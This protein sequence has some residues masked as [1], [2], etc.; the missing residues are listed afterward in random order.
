MG[1]ITKSFLANWAF[2]HLESLYSVP[3]ME[4]ETPLHL[5]FEFSQH[6]KVIRKLSGQTLT[7]KLLN[8]PTFFSFPHVAVTYWERLCV[9]EYI[10]QCKPNLISRGEYGT[11]FS[12]IADGITFRRASKTGKLRLILSEFTL[13]YVMNPKLSG[14]KRTGIHSSK[15]RALESV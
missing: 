12:A 14:G 5:T 9:N 10:F 8:V 7:T 11:M 1:T 13:E 2:I 3:S 6:C 15:F 4:M